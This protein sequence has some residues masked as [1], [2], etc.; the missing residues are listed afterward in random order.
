MK[1][2]TTTWPIGILLL[3]TTLGWTTA[4]RSAEPAEPAEP[5]GDISIL[6]AGTYFAQGSMYSR[7][8][9]VVAKE[10]AGRVCVKV[11]NGPPNPYEGYQSIT[12][13]TLSS[14][15]NN[16][17]IVAATNDPFIVQGPKE[18]VIGDGRSGVWKL[19]ENF[20]GNLSAGLTA[21]VT[22]PGRYTQTSQGP[23]ITGMIYPNAPG[24]L[25]AQQ[26]DAEINV[27]QEPSVQA[28]ILHYGVPS[29]RVTLLYSRRDAAGTMWYEVKF[30]DSGAQGWVRGDF[31]QRLEP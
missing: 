5:T 24:Q 22:A 15:P 19:V 30:P 27:R 10:D 13:S 21:C 9:R 11:V 4:A 14:Q 12:I 1:N 17:L 16:Q 8:Y 29:D 25:M 6:A 2:L 28:K 18:F 7:S 31:V 23:F 20:N 26:A 3:L